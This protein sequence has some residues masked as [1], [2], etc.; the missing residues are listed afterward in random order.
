[1]NHVQERRAR[2]AFAVVLAAVLANLSFN[3]I[4]AARGADFPLT[5]FLFDPGDRFADFFKLAFSYPGNPLHPSADAWG[6]AVRFDSFHLQTEKF[7]GTAINHFH[8][9]PLPTLLAL[10]TRGLMAWID[11][12]ILFITAT[13]IA[14]TSL[15]PVVSSRTSRLTGL[16]AVISYPALM[17]ID[18][19]NLFSA[20]SNICLIV[21]TLRVFEP[22]RSRWL[23]ILLFA[24]ALNLRPTMAIVPGA[25]WLMRKMRFTDMGAARSSGDGNIRRNPPDRRAALS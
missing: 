22:Q 3:A 1:M 10:L 9:P 25:L 7:R 21:A 14:L 16:L 12:V 4:A 5:T 17:M 13:A 15:Y 24:I 20:I 23:T 18:R 11:P 6:M 8:L 2:L 19:G